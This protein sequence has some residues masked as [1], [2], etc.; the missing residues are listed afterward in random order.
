MVILARVAGETGSRTG[1]S[2]VGRVSEVKSGKGIGAD[3][4]PR[5]APSGYLSSLGR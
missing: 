3:L 4:S 1:L 2:K 5:R